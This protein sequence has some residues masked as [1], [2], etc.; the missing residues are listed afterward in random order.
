MQPEQLNQL[1]RLGL[2]SGASDVHLKPG[3]PP[4]FRIN[5][6][7]QYL[8]AE[9]L[10]AA[11]TRAIAFH[12][13]ADPRTREVL[14]TL[15][16]Y[17]GAYSLA[18]QARFR[19]NLYRQRGSLSAILRIIPGEVPSLEQL[20]LPPEVVPLA[21]EE[22]G[23]VLVTGAS[24]SGKSTTLAALVNHINHTRNAHIVSIE[25]PIEYLH[26]NV[27]SSIS[28]REIGLDTANY[29]VALRAALRQDPDVILV[30]EIRDSEAVEISLKASE[31]GHV[32]Y[33]TIHTTD[34]SKTIGRLISMFPSADEASV[35]LRLADN[36]RGTVSQRLLP[37]ADG[38][39]RVVACEVMIV[40]KTV[41]Q[42]I[43][44]A[45][46]TGMLK[47]VIEK[48]KGSGMQSFD[49][50]LIELFRAGFITFDTAVSA[51]TNPSDFE[52]TLHFGG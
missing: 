40:T 26:R 20:G 12:L 24:G 5:G 47:D 2:Q 50:H 41:Q 29:H 23:L 18:G 17:D 19:V 10:T 34:A 16:E 35:R 15:Q 42:H 14:D 33:S 37:R 43:R 38:L 44:D 46:R 21:N 51:A 9:M 36:L 52:R 28:Q 39:G 4:A 27:Q 13:V 25:D 49:Q 11:A 22:R 30:G 7:L 45:D 6:R 48:G 31:T 3:T 8:Q 1:L 32:V